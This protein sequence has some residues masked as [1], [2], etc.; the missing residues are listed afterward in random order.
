MVENTQGAE[1]PETLRT[2]AELSEF[3]RRFTL[4]QAI[5]CRPVGVSQSVLSQWMRGRYNGANTAVT[6]KVKAFLRSHPDGLAPEVLAQLQ[7]ERLAHKRARSK[8]D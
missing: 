3:M 5:L 6:D 7:T 4:T 2:R 1:D 8:M